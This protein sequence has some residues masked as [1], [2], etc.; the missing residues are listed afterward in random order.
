MNNP[1]L[2]F[3]NPLDTGITKGFVF[4]LLSLF[5]CEAQMDK[6]LMQEAVPRT[7]HLTEDPEA[8]WNR[9]SKEEEE[10]EEERK[11]GGF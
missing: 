11:E 6:Q 2:I 9:N 5:I 1:A 7:P 8:S 4:L 10:E 3:S